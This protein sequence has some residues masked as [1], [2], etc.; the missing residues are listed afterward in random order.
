MKVVYK[1]PSFEGN[2]V[3]RF[4]SVDPL[5]HLREWVSPYN[6]VQNNPINRV[7]PTGALDEWVEKD[8]QMMY[9]NRVTKGLSNKKRTSIGFFYKELGFFLLIV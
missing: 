1:K 5:A 6:F 4:L 7:D 2:N 3:Q 9:D 8:G